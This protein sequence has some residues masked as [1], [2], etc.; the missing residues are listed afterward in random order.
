MVLRLARRRPF[1]EDFFGVPI[2][3]LRI[4]KSFLAEFVG[5]Q[6]VGFAVCDSGSRVGVLCQVVKFRES[7]VRALGHRSLLTYSMAC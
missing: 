5:G 2:G 4:L 1:C 6:M 7:I 3:V